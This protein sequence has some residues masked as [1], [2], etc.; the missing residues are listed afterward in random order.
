MLISSILQNVLIQ[1]CQE[2][3]YTLG[4]ISH[5]LNRVVHYW[6]YDLQLATKIRKKEKYTLN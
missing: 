4:I 2:F 5:E 6:V 3:N 1:G